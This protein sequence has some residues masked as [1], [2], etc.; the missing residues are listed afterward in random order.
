MKSFYIPFVLGCL[1][2]ATHA[3]PAARPQK[4]AALYFL[5]NNPA[6]SSVVSFALGDNG[7]PTNPVKTATGGVG[8][9]SLNATGSP[10]AADPLMS[11]GS[12][13]IYGNLLFT[14][15]SGDNTVSFLK[16]N[17][18]DPQHLQLV[19]RPAPTGGDFPVSLD[20]SQKL[21][22]LCVLDGGKNAGVTC[23]RVDQERG[24]QALAPIRIS[25]D[26]S[27]AASELSF[28]PDSSAVFVTLKGAANVTNAHILAYPIDRSGAVAREPVVSQFSNTQVPFGFQFIS[29]D[30]IYLADPSFGVAL[31]KVNRNF[32]VTPTA[33]N[34]VAGQ[35]AICWTAA[36]PDTKTLYGLDAGTDSLWTFSDTLASTGAVT[37]TEP[38]PGKGLFDAVVGNELL[39]ALGG[40]NGIVVVDTKMRKQ[41]DLVDLSAIGKR[42][43]FTGLAL[44]TC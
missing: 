28:N 25:A 24:L 33:K 4:P 9:I 32:T 15:N 40:A 21:N 39:Y 5:D 42:N 30:Q 37:L 16:I 38:S 43:G 26:A 36:D 44:Y 14:V 8:L 35:K 41:V 10:V 18:N 31:L 3:A 22:R 13:R 7:I 23:F 27:G 17:P 2:T 19:G 20:Y 34:V 29:Q 6:G 1:H 11:Q 12:V